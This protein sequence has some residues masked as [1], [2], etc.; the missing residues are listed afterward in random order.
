MN[1]NLTGI[2]DFTDNLYNKTIY[3][4]KIFPFVNSI[5]T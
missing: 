5:M 4:L 1:L 3:F 2:S